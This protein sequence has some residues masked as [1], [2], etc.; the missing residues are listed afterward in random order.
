VVS[1]GSCSV[2]ASVMVSKNYLAASTPSSTVIAQKAPTVT[3]TAPTGV[4]FGDADVSLSATTTSDKPVTFGSATPGVCTV[5]GSQLHVV[6]AGNCSI[7]ASVMVSKNYLAASTPSSTVIAQE[8]PTVTFT[9]PTGVT[10][11]DADVT[12]S[13]TTTSDKPVTFDASPPSVCSVVSGELHVVGA[14]SCAIT[15]SVAASKNY[16]AAS[17]PGVTSIAK[18]APSLTFVAPSGLSPGSPDTSLIATT[19]SDRPVTFGASPSAVCSV[20]LGKLHVASAGEC[21]ITAT[22]AESSN[23][24]SKAVMGH[25]TVGKAGTTI[26]SSPVS[27]AQALRGSFVFTATLTST[28]TRS[29]LGGQPVS[30]AFAKGPSP[31]GLEC[32]GV[33][34]SSGVATCSVRVSIAG[35]LAYIV[36]KGNIATYAGSANYLPSQVGPVANSR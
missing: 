9:A 29:G 7:T 23:F 34:N 5:S 11:G 6:S 32:S 27:L 1:A 35:L 25:T 24:L 2:I 8:M 12:L 30:F 15:A 20:V 4:T 10:F 3:F 13:A 18:K 21:A 19:S 26:T 28:V 16:L 22:V 36:T 33:T 31:G 17:T 14:G